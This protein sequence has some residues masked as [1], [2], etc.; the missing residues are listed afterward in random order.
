MDS[1]HTRGAF[2]SSRALP[3]PLSAFSCFSL[4]SFHIMHIYSLDCCIRLA[5]CSPITITFTFFA[6][7]TISLLPHATSH[8]PNVHAGTF[9]SD[10]CPAFSAAVICVPIQNSFSVYHLLQRYV[11]RVLSL[12]VV[13]SSCVTHMPR[14]CHP[15]WSQT[16]GPYRFIGVVSPIRHSRTCLN[17]FSAFALLDV[18][19]MCPSI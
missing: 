16:P 2:L 3:F 14:F 7:L 9:C 12:P 4:F 17:G 13:F 10:M 1:L 6:F 8:V 15:S 11:S 18:G 19:D 5:N